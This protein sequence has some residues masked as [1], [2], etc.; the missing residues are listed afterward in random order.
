MD[1]I[2]ALFP[3]YKV[4][5]EQITGTDMLYTDGFASCSDFKLI[6]RKTH[7]EYTAYIQGRE[8]MGFPHQKDLYDRLC[9]LLPL[10]QILPGHFVE[11]LLQ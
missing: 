6:F 10:I 1:S 7:I 3:E 11:P 2:Q 4:T 8:V 5:S 9:Q